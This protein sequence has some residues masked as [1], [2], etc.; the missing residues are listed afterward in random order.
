MRIIFFSAG[1]F[2]TRSVVNGNALF[3]GFNNKLQTEELKKKWGGLIN[4]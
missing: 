2:S 4:A 1:L 3:K